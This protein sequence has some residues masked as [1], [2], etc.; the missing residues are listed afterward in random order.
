MPSQEQRCGSLFLNIWSFLWACCVFFCFFSL[1][2][3]VEVMLVLRQPGRPPAAN[4]MCGRE[5]D[6]TTVSAASLIPALESDFF[7][8]VPQIVEVV[9]GLAAASPDRL[10]SGN[11][12][13]TS[14]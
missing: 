2:N 11:L 14:G 7:L 9:A 8:S 5:E 12:S 6:G 13:D 4:S 1:L 10:S 3:S